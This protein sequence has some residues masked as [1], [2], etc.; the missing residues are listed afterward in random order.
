MS[1][2]YFILLSHEVRISIIENNKINNK[3]LL[4]HVG[5]ILLL[6]LN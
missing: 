2:N 1:V 3:T 6:H 4:H 5:I